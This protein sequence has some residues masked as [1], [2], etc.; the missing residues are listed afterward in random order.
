MWRC[1]LVNV[2]LFASLSV[3]APAQSPVPQSVPG[4]TSGTA[5]GHDDAAYRKL[6]QTFSF[7]RGRNA[8]EYY[9]NSAKGI[10]EASFVSIGGIEQWVTIRG[11]NRNNPVSCSCMEGRA[12]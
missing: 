12:T 11:E 8:K 10:D 9:I 3:L 2:C 4:A 1:C 7:F 5:N 6:D